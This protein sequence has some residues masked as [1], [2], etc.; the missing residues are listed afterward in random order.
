MKILVIGLGGF[1]G[2]IMRYSISGWVYRIVGSGLP[3]GTLSVNILGSFILG[4]FLLFAEERFTISPAWRSF[5]AVGMMG[6]LTT[7]STFSYETFMML[8]ENLYGQV[9]LNVGLNVVLTIAAVWAGMA[10]ARIV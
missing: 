2:A 6:A 8:Q 1:I 4:F 5:I 7:F 10:L 9:A 3:Y